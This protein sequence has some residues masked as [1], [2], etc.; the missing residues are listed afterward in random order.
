MTPHQLR[1]IEEKAELDERRD[2]LNAFGQGDI[3]PTLPQDEQQRLI[4][5][6]KIMDQYS[7]VLAERIAAFPTPRI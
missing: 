7:V 4:R 6:C 3:F 1:V 5:Q 2:K